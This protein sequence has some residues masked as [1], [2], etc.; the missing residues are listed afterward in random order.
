MKPSLENENKSLRKV[1][2]LLTR[3]SDNRSKAI[4]FFSGFYYTHAAI[5]LEEDLDT[6]YSFVN[7]GFIVEKI[8]KYIKSNR[9]PF[10]C[11][12]YELKVTETVYNSIKKILNDFVLNKGL[13][14]YAKLGLIFGLFHIPIKQK[15]RYFCSQFVAEV[16]Q[17]SN[18]VELKKNSAIC[19]PR[20]L[21]KLSEL[22]LNFQGNLKSM[23]GH[24]FFGSE[25]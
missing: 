23:L 5:G 9:E 6:F 17:K 16:L 13:Y 4:G 11:Q 15:Y 7:K 21:Q 12:L 18:A 2:V 10:P 3:F 19:F 24:S 25:V 14:R 22:R 8:S 1:Y 20:D